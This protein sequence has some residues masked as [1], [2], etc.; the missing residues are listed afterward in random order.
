M[1][2]NTNVFCYFTAY[3]KKKK[4]LKRILGDLYCSKYNEINVCHSYIQ[5]DIKNVISCKKWYIYYKY[6]VYRFT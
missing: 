6:F 3:V 1:D 5:N 4:K 2:V